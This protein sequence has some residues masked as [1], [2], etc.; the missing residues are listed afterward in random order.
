M[1]HKNRLAVLLGAAMLVLG[2]AAASSAFAVEFHSDS[3]TGNTVITNTTTTGTSHKID[4]AGNNVTCTTASFSG[5]MAGNT[6]SAIALEATYSGC[7]FF[8]V[9][10]SLSMGN[11]RYEFKANGEAAIIDKPGKDCSAQPITYKA[12][13]LSSCHVTIGEQSG[14]KSVA[15]DGGTTDKGTITITPAISGITYTAT[16]SLCSKTGMQSDGNYT[17][18][19]T[20]LTC[21]VD[22]AGV[23][24]ASTPCWVA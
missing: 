24:G 17:S 20:S 3:S 8:G 18:G 22:T 11:C 15:Y 4:T 10:V 21:Y 19:T 1:T 12:L 5:T 13:F 9:S 23:E 16:G 6:A 2:A 14:L 7:T